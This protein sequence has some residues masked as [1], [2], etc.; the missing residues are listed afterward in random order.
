MEL[1]MKEVE[2]L[3]FEYIDKAKKLL[4]PE[5]WENVL[6]DCSKNEV[7]LIMFLYRKGH[8]NMSQ[9]ADYIKVPL[10][11]A[12]GIVARMEK[13]GLVMRE[14]SLEDKRVV[15]IAMTE[16]GKAYMQNLLGECLR[17]GE[18]IL[19]TLTPEEL[20]MGM[21]IMGKLLDAVE[22]ETAPKPEPQKKLRK[23]WIE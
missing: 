22:E 20:Q 15:L 21:Q 19:K 10:N 7:F 2:N 11:T 23:I 8:A 17:Y 16:A 1:G 13:K 3:I 9:V 4:S 5:T 12:T 18:I 14:R 6:M